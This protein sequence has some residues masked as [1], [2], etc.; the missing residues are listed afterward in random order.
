MDPLVHILNLSL[1]TGIIPNNIKTAKVIPVF[2]RVDPQLPSNYRPMSLLN[3]FSELL[4]KVMCKR[5]YSYLQSNNILYQ[6]Q[7][8]F[9][10]FY[11]T[12]FGLLDVVDNIYNHL[13]I[14]ILSLASIWTCRSLSTQ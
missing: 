14:D 10:K 9:R 3:V 7:F 2:K 11:S 12:T 6:Y 13:D 1:S 4:E 5:L 8:G